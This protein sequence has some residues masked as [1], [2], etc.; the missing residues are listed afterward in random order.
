M[1]RTFN[2]NYFIGPRHKSECYEDGWKNETGWIE[3]KWLPTDKS[4]FVVRIMQV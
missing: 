1:V 4:K 3:I 2:Y